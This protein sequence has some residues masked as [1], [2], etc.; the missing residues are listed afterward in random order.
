MKK[1]LG[2]GLALL[3]LA[4]CSDDDSDTSVKLDNLQKKWYNV[5]YILAGKTVAYDG[6]LACGKDYKEFSTN[7]DLKDVDYYDCQQDAR[8]TTG[9]YTAV[10]KT[11]T[12]SLGGSTTVYTIEK[13]DSKTLQ[14]ATTREGVKISYVYTSTP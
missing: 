3:C 7:Q 10:D 9:T 8:T 2:L 5:S 13:L 1:L 14:I 12:T 11:L 4:S 6:N